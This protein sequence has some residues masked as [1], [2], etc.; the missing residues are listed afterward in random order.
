MQSKKFIF[1]LAILLVLNLLIKPI[2]I[3]LVDPA[4]QMHVGNI[5]YGEYIVLFNFSF[6]SNILL[7]FGLTNFNNRNIAQNSQL[8]SKHFSKMLTLKFALGFFYTIITL[9]LAAVIWKGDTRYLKLL[10]VLCANNFL[11]SFILFLRSNIQGLHLFRVDSVISVLDRVIMLF[12]FIAMFNNWFGMEINIMSF[13]YAQTAGY[14]LTALIAF[15]VVLSKTE[16]FKLNWQWVFNWMILKKSFPF[17]V[18]VLLMTFYNRFDSV[19]IERILQGDLGKYQ[20]G[21]YAKAF[22]LLDAANNIALLFSVQL[23]PIFSRMLKFRE[24]IE[25]IVKLAFTLIIT[26]ALIVS[27]ACFFYADEFC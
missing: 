7:D 2:W 25:N 23:L 21:I 26:P 8:L 18:L 14:A 4:V 12:I 3:L 11:L 22:R 17:A 13:A 19:L 15:V 1:D 16:T 24:N 27:I 5:T 10:L 9:A 6:L 20:N